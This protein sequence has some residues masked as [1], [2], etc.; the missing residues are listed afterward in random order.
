MLMKSFYYISG[1]KTAA[2]EMEDKSGAIFNFRPTI[3]PELLI[4]INNFCEAEFKKW[5][6][7]E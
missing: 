3:T 2:V 7:G 1:S 6:D 4:S 5:K